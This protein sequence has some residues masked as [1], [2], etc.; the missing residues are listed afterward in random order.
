MRAARRLADGG[1]W[2]ADASVPTWAAWFAGLQRAADAGA[3]NKRLPPG[4]LRSQRPTRE[5]GAS[6]RSPQPGHGHGSDPGLALPQPACGSGCLVERERFAC[7]GQVTS[8]ARA[9][10]SPCFSRRNA[11]GASSSGNGS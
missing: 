6:L 2:M 10:S 8:T 1:W 3:S 4:F 11:S 9:R 7:C 5:C